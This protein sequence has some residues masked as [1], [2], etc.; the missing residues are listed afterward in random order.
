M[1]PMGHPLPGVE[2]VL[3]D[4]AGR[5][6]CRTGEVVVRT[7]HVALGYLGLPELTA[8]RF[9]EH[10]GV[11]AYR[12]GDVAPAAARR[13]ACLPEPQRPDGED[14]RLPGGAG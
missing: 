7:P 14:P 8:A 13:D 11:R 9:T 1:V 2:V 12:T 3:T 4:P 5:P 6:T 10:D